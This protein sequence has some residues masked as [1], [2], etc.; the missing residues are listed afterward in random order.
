MSLLAVLTFGASPLVLHSFGSSQTN[1]NDNRLRR[2]HRSRVAAV[3]AGTKNTCWRTKCQLGSVI[4]LRSFT[5]TGAGAYKI[6]IAHDELD[7]RGRKN[8]E[9]NQI[10]VTLFS[11]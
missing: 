2:V 5:A 4:G 8:T 1:K 9:R 10:K 6:F 3:A 7:G 11:R